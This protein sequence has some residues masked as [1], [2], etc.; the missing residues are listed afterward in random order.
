MESYFDKFLTMVIDGQLTLK[1]TWLT[2]KPV[3]VDQWPLSEE[4]VTHIEQLV[5]EQVKTGHLV[6]STSSWNTPIFTIPKKS[7]KWQLLQDLRA[8]NAVMQDMGNLQPGMPAP[9]MLP[10]DW[11]MIVID[12]QDCFFTIYLHPEDC[13]KFAFSVPSINLQMPAKR[14]HWVV[15]PQ[16]MENSPTICQWYVDLALQKA[17]AQLPN[18]IIYHYMDDLL[19]CVQNLDKERD[20][21]LIM[22]CLAEYGL[23]VAP[24]KIQ[25][26]PP[27]KYLGWQVTEAAVRPQR[28]RLHVQIKDVHDVQKLVGDIQWVRGQCGI[29]NSDLQPFLDMLR[30]ADHI[31]DKRSLTQ[32]AKAALQTIEEKIATS[33]SHRYT[34]AE[35]IELA[36]LNTPR[37]VTGILYQWVL[38]T[39]DPLWVLEWIYLPTQPHKTLTKRVEAF[40][41]IVTAANRRLHQIA[42]TA[43]DHVIL[44]LT[45]EQIQVALEESYELAITALAN[46]IQ[47]KSTY[48]P[49]PLFKTHVAMEPQT[50]QSD[51]PLQAATV[52]SDTSSKTG[53]TGFVW[54]ENGQWQSETVYASGSVQVMELAAVVRIFEKWL[55]EP[56]N[57]VSD[58]QYVVG[59]VIRMHRALLKRITNK[60]LYKQFLHLWHLDV[61]ISW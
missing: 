14:Y 2:E 16:G 35:P 34:P 37:E 60:D 7:G 3:W 55:H 56:I 15:L 42:G 45:Q 47:L 43:L 53:K 27:Y 12:L 22:D 39:P 54:Q 19:I 11:P 10:R 6:P 40:G 17:R 32:D 13:E 61:L 18:H 8:V 9:A 33:Y 31:S 21:K 25:L 48:P 23:V 36:V 58:S 44:P 52:F 49:H 28:L 29:L 20:L 51:I 41:L 4:K 26:T 46:N 30:T 57:V 5:E 59:L 24:E 50:C 1:I 38:G